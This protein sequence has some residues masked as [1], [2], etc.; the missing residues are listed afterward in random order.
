MPSQS[1]IYCENVGKKFCRDLKLSLRYGIR[2]CLETITTLGRSKAGKRNL[3][4]RPG[5]FWANRDISFE[6]KAGECLGL[7]GRNGAGKTTLLKLLNGLLRPDTGKIE[8]NGRV[9]AMIALGAGFN[10]VLTGRE[11]IFVNGSILGLSKRDINER[12]NEIIDFSEINDAIDAPVRTYSSGMYA[13]LGFAIATCLKPDILIVDEVLAVGDTDFRVKCMKR[14]RS[15]IEEGCAVILVSHNMTDIRNIAAK[16]LWL[17]NG[18]IAAYGDSASV[19]TKYLGTTTSTNSEIEWPQDDHAPGSKSLRLRRLCIKPR[20]QDDRISIESGSVTE[21]EFDCYEQNLKLGFT[22]EVSTEEQIIVFHTGG[23]ISSSFDS[24]VGKYNLLI[25]IPGNLL[26]SGKYYM[27]VI[28]DDSQSI[29]LASAPNAI[30]F[31]VTFDPVG[32]N[33]N[34]LPGVLSPKLK[35]SSEFRDLPAN[36]LS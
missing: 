28:I 3:D 22:L 30:T 31:Q 20:G 8:V 35:W 7:L 11:N 34:Q 13:R 33:Y 12:L 36:T 10:P 1:A 4:L 19:V 16:S 9:G 27:S 5:E 18:E 23:S 25:E 26:N 15:V 32:V 29:P 21:I 6:L 17:E 24:Q 14:M 2:D